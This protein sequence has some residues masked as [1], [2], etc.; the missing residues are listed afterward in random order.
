MALSDD[1]FRE[2]LDAIFEAYDASGSGTN[3]VSRGVRH[4]KLYELWVAAEVIRNLKIH[5]GY[6][7]TLSHGHAITLRSQGGPIDPRYPSFLLSHPRRPNLRLWTDIEFVGMS[8][9]L[10]TSAAPMGGE[11]WHELDLVVVKDGIVG[12]PSHQ[13]VLIGVECKNTVEFEKRMAREAFGVRRELSLRRP[14]RTPFKFWPSTDLPADPAS[15]LLVYASDSRVS[16][17]SAPGE[18]YGIRFEHYQ[19]P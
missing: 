2:K 16:R 7:A 1:Q 5:E 4:G 15:A 17:Y 11:Y 9:T 13:D 10:V 12:R 14:G 8:R 18:V 6:S 19:A 3:V